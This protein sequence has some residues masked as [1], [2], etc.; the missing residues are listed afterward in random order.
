M[1]DVRSGIRQLFRQKGS[2]LAAVL[3]LALGIGASSALF[4][5]IDATMLRPLPYPNPEQLVDVTAEVFDPGGNYSPTPSMADM[6]TWQ[7]ADDVFSAVA[8]WG[9]AFYGRILSGEQPERL[10]A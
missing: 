2:S 7:A 5:V 9:T 10:H 3:T 8:G 6:R 1:Q 4:S